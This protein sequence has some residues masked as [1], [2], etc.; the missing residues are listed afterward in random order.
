LIFITA[1]GVIANYDLEVEVDGIVV[2]GSPIEDIVQASRPEPPGVSPVGA[3]LLGGL[4]L[5][6][7]ILIL[8]AGRGF[9]KYKTKLDEHEEDIEFGKTKETL[10][11]IDSTIEYHMN[12]LVAPLDR[13]KERLERNKRFIREIKEGQKDAEDSDCTV[14]QLQD[15]NDQLRQQIVDIKGQ[16]EFAGAAQNLSVSSDED[17][18][19]VPP[20]K[21]AF[22]EEDFDIPAPDD[23][24][25]DF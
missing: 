25:D 1:Q 14:E 10:D 2:Q 8:F 4:S 17:F 22:D 19:F 3:I 16:K 23:E 12:P 20:P 13:L 7:F 18:V 21:Q 15:E 9:W 6:V 11:K 24:A 5:L